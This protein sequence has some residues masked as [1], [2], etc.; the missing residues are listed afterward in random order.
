MVQKN[1]GELTLYL[2]DPAIADEM[3]NGFYEPWLLDFIKD[4]VSGGTWI[5]CGANF[6]NHTVFFDKMCYNSKVVAIE[7]M[8]ENLEYLQRNVSVNDCDKTRIIKA[9][10]SDKKTKADAVRIG[11]KSQ[12]KIQEGRGAIQVVTIDS[13][14]LRDVRLI[15]MDVEGHEMAALKGAHETIKKYKPELFIEIWHDLD[16]FQQHLAQY[17]YEV[18]QRYCHAPVY[19]FSTNDFP[20]LLK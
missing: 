19:H 8:P 18:K 6:G 5:D 12:Y 10:V 7:P 20:K 17:G 14:K 2:D 9:A 3:G 15:K 13:L 4:N 1:I 11:R 16:K